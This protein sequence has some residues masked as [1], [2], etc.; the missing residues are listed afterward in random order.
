MSDAET[1]MRN[2]DFLLAL[3]GL[4]GSAPLNTLSLQR[5]PTAYWTILPY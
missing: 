3:T 2:Q 5:A 4:F 1:L